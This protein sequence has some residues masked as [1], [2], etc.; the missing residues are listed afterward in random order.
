[1]DRLSNLICRRCR[2]VIEERRIPFGKTGRYLQV[3][4]CDC[5]AM[6]MFL[7]YQ[8]VTFPEDRKT[9]EPAKRVS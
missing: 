1:M 2:T 7:R 4:G 8:N 3:I 5:Q 9:S 6:R